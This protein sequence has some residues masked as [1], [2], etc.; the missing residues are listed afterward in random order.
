MPTNDVSNTTDG[1]LDSVAAANSVSYP[2]APSARPTAAIDAGPYRAR[3]AA[4]FGDLLRVQQL[5]YR[6]FNLE[7]REGLET[8]H[9]TQRDAD[10]FDQHCHHLMVEHLPSNSVVGT[11]RLQT[12]AMARAGAGYYTDGEYD[13]SSLPAD[14][15]ENGIELGRACIEREHRGRQVLF[16]LWKGL[17]QYVSHNRKRW[18]FGCCSLTSQDPAEGWAA[19]EQLRTRDGIWPEFAVAVRPAY[20]CA[21]PAPEDSLDPRAISLPPLF[22]IYLRYGGKICSPPAIDRDFKTI[23]LLMLFDVA[24]LDA[25]ARGLFFEEG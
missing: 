5:R 18:F 22:E 19:L 25:R 11:Y 20:A 3:F 6:V 23:D 16:L 8:S 1:G 4:S 17:A 7:L 24:R 21:E 13:L 9:E 14:V 2:P 10:A 15:L 12:G